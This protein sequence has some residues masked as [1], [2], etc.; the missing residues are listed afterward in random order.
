MLFG[1]QTRFLHALFSKFDMSKV[2][3]Q[4]FCIAWI[5]SVL[6]ETN[7]AMRSVNP[8]DH[9]KAMPFQLRSWQLTNLNVIFPM[10]GHEVE[11]IAVCRP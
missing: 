10:F 6:S 5:E 8:R 2:S 3:V 4:F 11:K 1:I 9:T 7:F